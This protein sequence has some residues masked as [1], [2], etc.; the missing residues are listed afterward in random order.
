MKMADIKAIARER[1]IKAGKM[2]KG[3]LIKT[4]QVQEGNDACYKT[5][6]ACNQQDC[7]WRQSCLL[8]P[9][10][11]VQEPSGMSGKKKNRFRTGTK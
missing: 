10:K 11:G 4:I 8:T 3:T 6:T 2:N 7:C 1:G 5:R 9:R